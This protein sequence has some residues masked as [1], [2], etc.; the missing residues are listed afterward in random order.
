V[1]RNG[2]TAACT[3]SGIKEPEVITDSASS[4]G[5]QG[6]GRVS[7][8]NPAPMTATRAGSGYAARTSMSAA[9]MPSCRLAVLIEEQYP[10]ESR[11]AGAL[12]AEVE[13]ARDP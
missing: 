8:P 3:L 1:T 7:S 10:G 11:R 12:D 5:A 2:P 9:S 4:H 6:A 13:G